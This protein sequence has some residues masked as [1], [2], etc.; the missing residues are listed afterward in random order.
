MRSWPASRPR[1]LDR[2]DLL[3]VAPLGGDGPPREEKAPARGRHHRRPAGRGLQGRARH[4]APAAFIAA[5]AVVALGIL[6]PA[7][8]R[9]AVD[10]EVIVVIAASVG[11]GAAIESSGLAADLAV[12]SGVTA[13]ATT[14]ALAFPCPS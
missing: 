7:E 14:R 3:V 8:A 6:T 10:L 13:S 9:D 1:K 5:F 11:I 12:G 4:P 2:R